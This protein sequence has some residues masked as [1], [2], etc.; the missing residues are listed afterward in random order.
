MTL[1]KQDGGIHTI[2]CGEIWNHCFGS[3]T[4]NST[5]VRNEE[6]KLFTSTYD[7]FI[8]ATGIRDGVSHYVKI[9]WIFYDILDT[10]DLNDPEVFIKID[11]SNVFHSTC[12][13]LTLDILSGQSSHDY[14]CDLKRGGDITTSETLSNMFGYFKSMPHVTLNLNPCH[15][16]H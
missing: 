16:P 7:N 9:L 6:T 4:V 15:M 12:R 14:V 13:T 2:L 5:S 1:Q 3:L 8:Q 10:T 11:I